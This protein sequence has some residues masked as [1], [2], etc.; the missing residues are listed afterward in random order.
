MSLE[1]LASKV[2]HRSEQSNLRDQKWSLE[3][4]GTAYYP[5]AVKCRAGEVFGVHAWNKHG[6]K[7]AESVVAIQNAM[8]NNDIQ[9]T[10]LIMD[11]LNELPSGE[12]YA[13]KPMRLCPAAIIW[14]NSEGTFILEMNHGQEGKDLADYIV[15]LIDRAKS[16]SQACVN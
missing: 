12:F 3:K 10:S 14:R 9:N 11:A 4:G 7:I 15:S 2:N 6:I 13:R 5:I 1:T 16:L 8:L